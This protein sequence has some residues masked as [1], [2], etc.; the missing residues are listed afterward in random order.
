MSDKV[1]IQSGSG[2]F[3][4]IVAT[5]TAMI[6]HTIHGSI[7]WSIMDF[8]FAPLAWIKWLIM[9]QVTMSIIRDTF[10]WFFN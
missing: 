1:Y 10:S 4:I 7:F 6:G 3:T 2:L 5:L 8:L 9:Q